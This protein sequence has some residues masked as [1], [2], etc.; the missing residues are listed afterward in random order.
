[1]RKPTQSE[2]AMLFFWRHNSEDEIFSECGYHDKLS[3]EQIV[4][5][6]SAVDDVLVAEKPLPEVE[7]LLADIKENC[8]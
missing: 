4:F 1:M 7:D 2:I 5:L 8:E 6:Q 3:A